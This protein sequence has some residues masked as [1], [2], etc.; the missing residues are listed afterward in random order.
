[1]LTKPK[2]LTYFT[3]RVLRITAITITMKEECNVGHSAR[4]QHCFA[5]PVADVECWLIKMLCDGIF[6]FVMG[7][8]Y[9]THKVHYLAITSNK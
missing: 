9:F 1:M 4:G 2:S 8:K 6:V 5:C 7:F 3:P